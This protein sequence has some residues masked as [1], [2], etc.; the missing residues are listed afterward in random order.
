MKK[1][2]IIGG[3]GP[4]STIQYYRMLIQLY[5][6][7]TGSD[8]YPEV[9]I[10]SIDMTQ[11]LDF[12]AKNELDEL[13]GFLAERIHVLENAGVD[14]VALASNTPH[15][16]LER[17]SEKVNTQLISIVEE[18]C[19]TISQLGQTKVL[20]LGTKF[21][22]SK[23]FYQSKAKEYGIEMFTPKDSDQEFIHEKY[24]RELVFNQIN[25]H[26]KERLIEIVNK[27]SNRNGLE[28]IVLGGTE[29]PLI[30]DETD[31]SELTLFNTTR[32]HVEAMLQKMLKD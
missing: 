5:R 19:K 10:Q 16:V 4:E 17:L 25:P 29:L 18:T 13:I 28:G 3:I 31:F 30:L 9:L 24:M 15:L 23:G 26:T 8:H 32:I 1:I 14:Y 6:E 7:K 27:E 21:T 20:L 11:M 12:I 2:G 22:M